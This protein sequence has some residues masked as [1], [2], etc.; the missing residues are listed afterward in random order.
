M[1][2]ITYP[3][4]YLSKG[5]LG[6]YGMRLTYITVLRIASNCMRVVRQVETKYIVTH[7]SVSNI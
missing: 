7:G 1:D 3:C 6:D 2:A 4:P 5:G